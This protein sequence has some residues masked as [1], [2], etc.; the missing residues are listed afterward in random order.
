MRSL[1]KNL[2]AFLGCIS[3]ISMVACDEATRESST[4]IQRPLLDFSLT[5]ICADGLDND[6]DGL[7]DLDDPGCEGPGDVDESNP[8]PL[9]AC[10]DLIDNDSDGLSDLADPGCTSLDD[11]DESDDPQLVACENGVDDDDDGLID[12]PEDPGCLTRVDEDESNEIGLF[13]CN[14]LIDDDF[15]G[16][17]D[18]PFDPGCASSDDDDERDDVEASMVAQCD[19]GLDDDGDGAVDLADPECDSLSDPRERFVE[20]DATP[21]CSNK[22]DDD[23]DGLVDF[24]EDPGCSRASLRSEEDPQTPPQCFNQIDDDGDGYLDYPQ[25]PGCAGYGDRDETDPRVRPGC[26]DG[27]DNDGDGMIDY[28]RDSG[29]D[30]ASDVSERGW[31]GASGNVIEVTDGAVYR[32]SSRQGRFERSASCGGRGAPELTFLYQV[33]EP[34]RTLR[35]KTTAI[36]NEEAETSEAAW[37]TTLYAWRD[38]NAPER[39]VSCAREPIDGVAE[40]LLTLVDPPIGPLYVMVDGAS[41]RGG[42]FQLTVEVIPIEAC[43]NERDDDDDGLI[44]FPYDPGCEGFLDESEEDPAVTPLCADSIDN[45]EDGLTDFPLDIG[46]RAAIDDDELDECGQG[47]PVYVIGEIPLRVDGDSRRQGMASEH[48]GSCGTSVGVEQIFVYDNPSHAA[49]T[50]T[51]NRLDGVTD[52]VSLHVRARRCLEEASELGCVAGEVTFSGE[53]QAGVEVNPGNGGAEIEPEVGG[54]E[55]GGPED[56]IT[57]PSLSISEGG[58]TLTLDDVPRG[59]IYIFVDHPIDGFPFGLHISRRQLSPSCQDERDNDGDGMIDL[60]DDGCE[61]PDDD[62][63]STPPIPPACFDDEDNDGDGLID[64]PID[65]G[66]SARGA[67][68]E[69]DMTPPPACDNGVDDN[70]DGETDFPYDSGCASAGDLSESALP[71]PPQCHNRV[72]D[73][74]DSFIDFPYDPGCSSRGDLREA[75]DD[76]IPQCIDGLD[77]DQNGVIDYPFDSGCYARG[78]DRESPPDHPPVCSDG[79]D[80]D[81]DGVTDFPMES[82]CQSAGD[83]SESDPLTSPECANGVDDDR[84][85]RIDWPD[86]PGC[87]YRGDVVEEGA[88]DLSPRCNDGVDNDLDGAVDLDDPQC[89]S[90]T[91]NQEASVEG[92]LEREAL[93]ECADGVDNDEDGDTDWPDDSGCHA[94]GGQCE[95]G[96]HGLCELNATDGDPAIYACVDLLSSADHCGACGRS[97]SVDEECLLG[98]CGGRRSL[99]SQIKYCGFTSLPIRDLIRGP[100][101][102]ESFEIRYDCEPNDE[103]QAMFIPHTHLNAIQQRKQRLASYVAEGGQII[104]EHGSTAELYEALFGLYIEGEELVGDCLDNVQPATQRTPNDPI[105]SLVPFSPP[106]D[107]ETGCGYALNAYPGIIHLGGWNGTQTSIGYADYGR[108]RLWLVESDWQGGSDE[109]TEE[110]LDLMAAMI[111][112]GGAPGRSRALP[113]CMDGFDNDG[114]GLTDLADLGCRKMRDVDERLYVEGTPIEAR[115]APLLSLQE[116]LDLEIEPPECFDGVDNDLNGVIDW[117]LDLNCEAQGAPIEGVSAEGGLFN[118]LPECADGVDNDLNGEIDWP[119]DAGCEGRGDLV[120]RPPLSRPTCANEQDDDGDELIDYPNDPDCFMAASTS[121]HGWSRSGSSSHSLYAQLSPSM[122]SQ[123]NSGREINGLRTPSLAPCLNQIDDD[124]DGL[125]DFPHDPGCQSARDEDEGLFGQRW[126]Q[127]VPVNP[128]ATPA[129]AD[130]IDNDGDGFI[131][132]PEDAGCHGR[133]DL[134][135]SPTEGPPTACEDDRDND[136]NGAIDYPDD[137]TC[138]S[139]STSQEGLMITPA[140]ACSDGLDNDNDG[141][142]DGADLGCENPKDDQEFFDEATPRPICSDLI[143]NDNDGAIDWP[144]DLGC[145]MAGSSREAQGCADSSEGAGMDLLSGDLTLGVPLLAETSPENALEGGHDHFESRCGG[146]GAPDRVYRFTLEE[147]STIRASLIESAFKGTLSLRRACL[148]PSAE[149]RC[150]SEGSLTVYNAPAGEYYLIVDGPT[151]PTWESRRIPLNL[152]STNGYVS[153]PDIGRLCWTDAGNDAYDCMGRFSITWRNQEY[154][155]DV[156][157]GVHLLELDDVTL[158]YESAL[159]HSN[160]WR[161]RFWSNSTVIEEEGLTLTMTGNLGTDQRTQRLDG[162]LELGIA[163]T[164]SEV[165]FIYTAD[166]FIR[167]SKPPSLITLIP[168]GPQEIDRISMELDTDIVTVTMSDVHL[169]ITA[170]IVPSFAHRSSTINLI[171]RDLDLYDG[172]LMPSPTSG[173]FQALVEVI[174]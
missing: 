80:N 142:I 21:I 61:D 4:S 112:G 26:L 170:Y 68:S 127:G 77:N 27:E 144:E 8:P 10:R 132:Y 43:Q 147:R 92:D 6:E 119:G 158:Y 161:V 39:E 66:C 42:T 133:G 105:W 143:D 41:G 13:E 87:Q 30:S 74:G 101:A 98:L 120:E 126:G 135:E 131:D 121:E 103:T 55:N 172:A 136:G 29:C 7:I 156:S 37:E 70:G 169:P 137:P 67:L 49:L 76:R 31:C 60:D 32:G 12:F 79:L 97:C 78:D 129:C 15:D 106:P 81:V 71:T 18:Y 40:N 174:P 54:A 100:I 151:Q 124:G 125:V 165:P 57:D 53:D 23:E 45:D 3:C 73:D 35:F 150:S 46:C 69:E 88:H 118:T 167:P 134:D 160:I 162:A 11:D 117:P 36:P 138:P 16:Y 83:Q 155:L 91:D 19:N 94:R 51:L 113:E 33:R 48:I 17:V 82:G 173:T 56:P 164:T 64:Y 99:R 75:N 104:T 14:N 93:S 38:C 148:D 116:L 95:R 110:S 139:A 115:G 89:S 90:R 152:P 114:D 62:D 86:D 2:L 47:L 166:D 50:L 128:L 149:L 163:P 96:G 146:G 123:L 72:D 85:G 145:A 20:G 102:D 107:D 63:E 168:R 22:L 141:L 154:D 171:Q 109:I 111:A 153:T 58:L 5:Q 159:A 122:R 34:V 59:L 1:S 25:D 140:P 24:P 65:P 108:G 9:N 84:N 44:D 28:P 157:L 130:E 52:Q